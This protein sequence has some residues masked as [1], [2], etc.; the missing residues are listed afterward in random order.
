MYKT[1]IG[2]NAG[3]IWRLLSDKGLLS[4]REIVEFTNYRESFLFL[5]LGWLARENKIRFYE[6]D[7]ILHVKLEDSAPIWYF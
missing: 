2:I 1:D 7:R 5:A 4:I 3:V 6:K